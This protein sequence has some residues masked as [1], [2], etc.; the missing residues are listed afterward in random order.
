MPSSARERFLLVVSFFAIHVVWGSTYLAI[1][2]AIETIPPLL[3][4]SAR[5]LLGG[6]ALFLWCWSRG[7]RPTREEWR[8]SAILA[9]MFFLVGHG[10]LHWAETYVPSGIAALLT[11]LEP[12]WI[13]ALTAVV[14]RKRMSPP[15]IGGLL[16]G[17]AAVA[18]LVGKPAES[19]D[20]AA[21]VASIA[22]VLG[23]LSW[24]AGMLYA[25]S[26]P[27]HPVPLMS[28]AMTLLCGGGWLL[29]GAIAKGDVARFHI[30]EVS[31]RS[32]L[33]LAYLAILGSLTFAGYSWLLTR[34]SLVLVA[35]HAYTNPLIAVLLGA[36]IASEPL[37]ARVGVS[38]VAVVMSI[39]LVRK[40]TR[41]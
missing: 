39:V 22:L 11:S 31:T 37:D 36:L 13:A 38:A 14:D 12:V 33:G 15:M 27:L 1:R 41:R 2:F 20:R 23:S 10:A 26:A 34:M 3:T 35:T 18:L 6:S 29:L 40:G 16:L 7:L 9:T 4:A 25:R 24:A 30:A 8:A 19:L 17:I 5:H 21:F 32:L 28:S